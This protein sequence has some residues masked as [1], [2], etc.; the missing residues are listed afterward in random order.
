MDY[1]TSDLRLP[2]VVVTVQC[3]ARPGQE[4]GDVHTAAARA[5]TRSAAVDAASAAAANLAID[6]SPGT[7]FWVKTTTHR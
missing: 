6:R 5:D 1:P 7:R 2:V 3:A 4:L